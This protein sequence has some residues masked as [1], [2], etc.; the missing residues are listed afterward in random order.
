M[1]AATIRGHASSWAATASTRPYPRG[2]RDRHK[3]TPPRAR[4]VKGAAGA[5]PDRR[6]ARRSLQ[7]GAP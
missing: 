5:A 1:S 2:S 6:S 4:A 3:P 7:H